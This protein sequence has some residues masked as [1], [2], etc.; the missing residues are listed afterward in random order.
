MKDVSLSFKIEF[1]SKYS[2]KVVESTLIM[3]DIEN[4]IFLT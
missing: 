1:L 3:K 2:D 4:I